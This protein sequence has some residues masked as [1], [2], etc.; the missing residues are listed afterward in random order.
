M[1]QVRLM[2]YN[3]DNH[4]LLHQHLA[5]STS[6]QAGSLTRADVRRGSKTPLPATLGRV[7]AVTA[8]ISGMAACNPDK[9]RQCKKI[10]ER[11]QHVDF[12]QAK[13]VH[14]LA[15]YSFRKKDGTVV[16]FPDDERRAKAELSRRQ[17]DM[18]NAQ[19]EIVNWC[20]EE[21]SSREVDCLHNSLSEASFNS[22]RKGL[23]KRLESW[24]KQ[25]PRLPGHNQRNVDYDS[26]T[27]VLANAHACLSPSKVKVLKN[28]AAHHTPK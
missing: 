11:Y 24:P 18:R 22:I 7:I 9:N 26:R 2:T 19:P 16:N 28:A 15:L 1:F 17:R 23:G 3:R 13:Y 20:V 8:I 21:L 27:K 25:L 6:G 5:P 4:A 10:V 14:S 12:A